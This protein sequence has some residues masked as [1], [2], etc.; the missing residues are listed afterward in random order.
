MTLAISGIPEFATEKE[1]PVD[2]W[3]EL[4]I[5]FKRNKDG[6]ADVVFLPTVMRLRKEDV[7]IMR[8]GGGLLS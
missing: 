1:L 3:F 6:S 5:R 4:R 2:Q 7:E 8:G